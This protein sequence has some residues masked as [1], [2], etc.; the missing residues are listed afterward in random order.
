MKKVF[1]LIMICVICFSFAGCSCEH[2]Y[3]NGVVTT[4][5]SCTQQ[6]VMPYACQ[7]CGETMTETIPTIAHSYAEEIVK[8]ATY[9]EEGTKKYTCSSCGDNYTEA[10]PVK[11]AEV[12]ITV[13][14]KENLPMDK[15][16]WRFSDYVRLTVNIE[17][18]SNHSIKGIQGILVVKDMFGEEFLRSN[19]DFTDNDIPSN[20]SITVTELYLDINQFMANHLKL[21]NTDYD[22]LVFEYEVKNVIF[23]N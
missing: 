1:L 7:E 4:E 14:E 17:N 8:E 5:A 11:D 12:I 19:C 3:D 21:F 18:V 15:N 10:I 16:A 22:D 9:A 23:T 20:S 2:T 13:T 6:G